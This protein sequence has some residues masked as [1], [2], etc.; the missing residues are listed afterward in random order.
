MEI[1]H[2]GLKA[3]SAKRRFGTM[4]FALCIAGA[5]HLGW[6]VPSSF[7]KE[8]DNFL[9]DRESCDHWRGEAGYDQERLAD[10]NWSVCQSCTGTDAKLKE[11]KKKYRSHAKILEKLNEFEPQIEPKDRAAAKRFC[12]GTRK[13]KWMD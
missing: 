12:Q 4:V 2:S 5:Y 9:A 13:P 3:A 7:P 10:I 1:E 6:A 8:I 11:L